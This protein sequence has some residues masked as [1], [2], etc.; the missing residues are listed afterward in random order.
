MH[1]YFS[2]TVFFLAKTVIPGKSFKI[3]QNCTAIGLLLYIVSIVIV[4]I[5][6]K[7]RG[8]K[9]GREEGRRK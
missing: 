7:G 3:V 5:S 4:Y 1:Y 9:K 2:K 8:R 6:I